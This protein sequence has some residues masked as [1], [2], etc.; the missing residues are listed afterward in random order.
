MSLRFGRKMG[1]TLFGAKPLPVF[2]QL[3]TFIY[4]VV[5]K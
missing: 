3:R 5:R 4:E 2:S 1:T